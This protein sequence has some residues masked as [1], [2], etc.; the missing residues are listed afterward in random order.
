[1]LAKT[2]M[3]V[4]GLINLTE[5]DLNLGIERVQIKNKG[6]G[7]YR[8]K[9]FDSGVYLNEWLAYRDTLNLPPASPLFCCI[10]SN[11]EGQEISRFYVAQMLKRTATHAGLGR[12]VH[13][14]AFRH[15]LACQLSLLGVPMVAIRDQ[16][17]H[18]A[19]HTTERYLDAIGAGGAL[20][21]LDGIELAS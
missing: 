20:K 10:S 16:L 9:L 4:S 1:M 5:L 7:F 21:L 2:G 15:T 17:G 8:A 19:V 11:K 14:H 3:R 6:G 12:R 18:A 13:A